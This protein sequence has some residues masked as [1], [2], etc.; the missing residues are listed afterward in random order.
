MGGS[1]STYG[2]H[3]RC[4]Q[5]FDGGPEGKKKLEDIGVEGMIILKLILKKWDG[6]A[7]TR[8]L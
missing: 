3:E 2:G 6:E 7:R 4:I 5:G 8:L 1:C